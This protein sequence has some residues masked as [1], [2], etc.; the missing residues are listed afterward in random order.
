MRRKK[1]GFRAVAVVAQRPQEFAA[2][3]PGCRYHERMAR[4]EKLAP[5]EV[6]WEMKSVAGAES[7]I[8]V[9]ERGCVRIRVHQLVRGVTPAMLV[10][11]FGHLE[12]EAIYRGKAVP[13]FRLWHPRDHIALAVTRRDAEG[14]CGAGARLRIVDVMGDDPDTLTDA[15]VDV[16]RFDD[17]GWAFE[18]R[19]G[20]LA[21]LRLEHDW[22]A[23]D[24]GVSYTC[25]LRLGSPSLFGQAIL[26]R[27]LR[28]KL[29]PPAARTAFVKSNVEKIG[30][31]EFFLPQLHASALVGDDPPI[32]G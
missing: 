25:G 23:A 5:L 10:W 21:P 18:K 19:A 24:G 17:R 2:L 12:G 22:A 6:A 32:A 13:R 31:F 7:T 28:A 16:V 4:A 1:L 29:M 8:A 26:N 27:L 9:D 20:P 30:N 15:E 11:W 14:N 3:G